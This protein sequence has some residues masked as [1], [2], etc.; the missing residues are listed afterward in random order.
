LAIQPRI[1]ILY[2]ALVVLCV[3]GGLALLATAGEPALPAIMD[4]N[5]YTPIMI[6]VVSTVLALPFLGLVIL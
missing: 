5:H 4:G 2:S 1:A 6:F 3:V